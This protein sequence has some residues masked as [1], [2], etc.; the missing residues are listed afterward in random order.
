MEVVNWCSVSY[1]L[2]DFTLQY[3]LKQLMYD[4]YS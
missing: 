2:R 3:R 1:E 4:S